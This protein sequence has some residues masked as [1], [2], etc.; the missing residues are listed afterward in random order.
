M[1]WQGRTD[2]TP[3]MQRQLINGFR[4]LPLCAYYAAVAVAVP[5]YMLFGKGFKASYGFYR[6]RMKWGRAKAL[7]WCFKNHYRFGQVMIDRFARYA[8][9]TFT[10]TTEGIELYNELESG[11]DAFVML[12]AHV[13][14]FEMG[15]YTL[16][17]KRKCIYTLVFAQETETVMQ[18]REQQFERTNIRMVPVGNGM[19]HLFAINEALTTGQILSMTADRRLGSEKAVTC[20]FFDAEARFPLGPFATIVQRDVPTLMVLVVK[21]GRTSYRAEVHHLPLPDAQLPRKERVKRLAQAY[22]DELERVVRLHPEQ[23]FNFFSLWTTTTSPTP[24]A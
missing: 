11:P 22:A 23:W 10:L 9:K 16:V 1:E 19:G 7:W 21:T 4:L 3:W 6:K 24:E 5:F 12:S 14:N 17:A 8:G 15:G 20:R 2:G 18:N 13:G